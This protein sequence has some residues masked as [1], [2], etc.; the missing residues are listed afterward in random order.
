MSRESTLNRQIMF[1]LRRIFAHLVAYL[2]KKAKHNFKTVFFLYN[3]SLGQF[4]Y[5]SDTTILK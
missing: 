3:L 1:K 2:K 4:I 5:S